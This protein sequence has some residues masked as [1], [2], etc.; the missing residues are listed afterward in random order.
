[1]S[2]LINIFLEP[3]KVFAELKE[4]P[5]FL[6]PTLVV[7]LLA[8]LS[9]LLYHLNV[10]PDWFVANRDAAMAGQMSKAEL[11]QVTA[12]LPGARASGYIG[13]SMMLL[14]TA[15]I[16]ALLGLYYLLAG[17][18]TGNAVGYKRAVALVA[19]S[20]MPMVVA[21][22][23]ALV[24]TYTSSNQ[25]TFESLQLLSLDPLF[26]QLPMDHDWSMFAKSFSLLTFWIIFL[27]AL[28]WKT[29]FH[30]GWG[31]AVSVAAFPWLLWFGGIA[32]F[33]AF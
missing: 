20:A 10:D 27:A 30:T 13:A 33:A 7:V 9:I 26:V 6:V 21:S 17:K 11:A 1:M 19:W 15:V 24:G 28:G 16:Y 5:T 23:I 4:K 18:I 14:M 25:T 2:Q 32:L 3:G 31:Q 8:A 22:V 29:W 12:F